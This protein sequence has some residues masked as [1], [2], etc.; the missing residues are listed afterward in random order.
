MEILLVIGKKSAGRLKVTARGA[1]KPA[2]FRHWRR[3]RHHLD[4][5]ADQWPGKAPHQPEQSG[6][7]LQLSPLLSG[8]GLACEW[9]APDTDIWKDCVS[10]C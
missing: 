7:R 4:S 8:S 10:A 2:L 3:V 5:D 6:A 1:G 9:G